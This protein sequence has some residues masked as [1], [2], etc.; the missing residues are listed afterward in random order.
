MSTNL[1]PDPFGTDFDAL[2]LPDHS[3]FDIL[4]RARAEAAEPP[5]KSKKPLRSARDKVLAALRDRGPFNT[6]I[7]TR[8]DSD[9][10]QSINGAAC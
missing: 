5:V 3:P 2:G 9:R 8:Q 10:T 7:P 1:E 4:K 6:P